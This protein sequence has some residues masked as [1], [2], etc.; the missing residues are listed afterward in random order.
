MAKLVCAKIT[1]RGPIPFGGSF[2]ANVEDEAVGRLL[3]EGW[4]VARTWQV[5]EGANGH[6]FSV[7]TGKEVAK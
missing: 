7:D 4:T 2:H 6:L 1:L 5:F 3:Q